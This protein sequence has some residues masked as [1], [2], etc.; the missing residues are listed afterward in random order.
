MNKYIIITV[1]IIGLILTILP[2]ILVFTGQMDMS[3]HKLW[4][5]VGTILWFLT[6]PSWLKEKPK[7]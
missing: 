6:A 1:A 4:M 5:T 7:I 3:T 2:S